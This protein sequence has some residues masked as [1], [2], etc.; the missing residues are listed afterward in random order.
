MDRLKVPIIET[1]RLML[2]PVTMDDA[3][4]M[5]AYAG[6]VE[7]VRWVTFPAHPDLESTKKAIEEVFLSRPQRQMP[8]AFAVV[9][10]SNQKMIGTCD[11]V[12][13]GHENY[14]LGYILNQSYW[15]QGYMSEAVM[16]VLQ[17]AFSQFGVRRMEVR[18]FKENIAS[19]KVIEKVGFIYEGT[20]RQELADTLGYYHDVCYYS[21]LK[22]EF[23]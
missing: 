13:R 19:Q 22:E 17:F 18:H 9:L 21:I 11:F 16:A 5:F 6:N 10:K 8:E 14:E 23:Q 2:R 1:E 20:K 7:N 3:E 4:D 15:R 12:P